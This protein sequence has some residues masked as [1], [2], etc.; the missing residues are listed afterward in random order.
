[1]LLAEE[2]SNLLLWSCLSTLILSSFW[3]LWLLA[4]FSKVQ[5]RTVARQCPAAVFFFVFLDTHSLQ[6]WIHIP[7][8]V[9]R[10]ST[11]W[12]EETILR[13]V[14]FSPGCVAP[15]SEVRVF[16]TWIFALKYFRK[17][18]L[19]CSIVLGYVCLRSYINYNLNNSTTR[20]LWQG[21]VG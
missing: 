10:N 19:V 4:A 17:T 12:F 20:L 2:N 3:S 14:L 16:V 1:M 15:E 5:K 21:I 13:V 7:K 9:P 18:Y 11:A 8:V 6:F